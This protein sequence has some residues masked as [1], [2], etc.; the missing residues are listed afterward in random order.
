MTHKTEYSTHMRQTNPHHSPSQL[1]PQSLFPFTKQTKWAKKSMQ[2]TSVTHKSDWNKPTENLYLRC[3]LTAR[4]LFLKFLLYQPILNKMCKKCKN[5]NIYKKI[6]HYSS[7]TSTRTLHEWAGTWN[8]N[9]DN[10]VVNSLFPSSTPTASS[11]PPIQANLQCT[12]PYNAHT[13][14][15]SKCLVFLQHFLLYFS[16]SHFRFL[17]VGCFANFLSHFSY[18]SYAIISTS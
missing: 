15:A 2:Q 4:F 14:T 6:Q 7:F 17:V 1:A 9:L 13:P 18:C 11:L 12:R 8:E 16:V 3:S 5:A 10:W